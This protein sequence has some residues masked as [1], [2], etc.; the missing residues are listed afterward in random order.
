MKD[1]S[2]KESW[3]WLQKAN[4]WPGPPGYEAPNAH[5]G[6]P[7]DP[8]LLRN[9]VNGDKFEFSQEATDGNRESTSAF[10]HAFAC[11]MPPTLVGKEDLAA[12]FPR[13]LDRQC[14]ALRTS[15]GLGRSFAI[16]W[17][18][19]WHDQGRHMVP[20]GSGGHAF[21]KA[22]VGLSESTRLPF[23]SIY[24]AVLHPGGHVVAQMGR[25]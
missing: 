9:E 5:I 3:N 11:D 21:L 10:L 18:A 22:Q 23:T 15:K 14:N 17:T 8:A 19:P 20:H 6:G 13:L 2:S 12:T 7:R 4:A 1:R 24:Q 16:C 25:Q